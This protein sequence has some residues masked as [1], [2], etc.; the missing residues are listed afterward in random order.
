MKG[1]A[2]FQLGQLGVFPYQS[3]IVEQ[4]EQLSHFFNKVL[5]RAF[6]KHKAYSLSGGGSGGRCS[7]EFSLVVSSSPCS[8]NT[9]LALESSSDGSSFFTPESSSDGYSL[10]SS[11]KGIFF[12]L[13]GPVNGIDR[14]LLF[15][16]CPSPSPPEKEEN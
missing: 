8:S 9:I 16:R 6:E 15:D 11:L 1:R 5:L 2:A 10:A 14:G 13:V 3:H 7:P 4:A 12:P